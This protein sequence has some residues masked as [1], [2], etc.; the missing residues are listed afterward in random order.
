MYFLTT[1]LISAFFVCSVY[2]EENKQFVRPAFISFP[3]FNPGFIRHNSV[4][5][6]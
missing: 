4:M 5:S 6:E 2:F 1:R 3:V